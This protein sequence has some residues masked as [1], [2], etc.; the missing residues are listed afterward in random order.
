MRGSKGVVTEEINSASKQGSV[1][2]NN[3]STMNVSLSAIER[4]IS[5]LNTRY[6]TRFHPNIT[7]HHKQYHVSIQDITSKLGIVTQYPIATSMQ[8]AKK[9]D[10]LQ[11]NEVRTQRAAG[12]CRLTQA[13]KNYH[14]K[15]LQSSESKQI[16][17]TSSGRTILSSS[18][19]TI[20]TSEFHTKRCNY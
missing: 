19:I 17:Q 3:L 6:H 8:L 5:G 10:S 1:Y 15:G 12:T 4:T 2:S 14:V 18:K 11:R 13:A 9:I 20:S 7:N 16:I